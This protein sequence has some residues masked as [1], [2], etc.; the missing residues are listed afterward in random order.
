VTRGAVIK[1]R[2]D[3]NKTEILGIDD[4]GTETGGLSQNRDVRGETIY[5]S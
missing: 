5:G 2:H 1:T 4:Y 3:E